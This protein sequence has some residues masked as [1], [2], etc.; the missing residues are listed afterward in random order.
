[1]V[2]HDLLGR[3]RRRLVE[4]QRIF[5]DAAFVWD[6]T[7]DEGAPVPA[8]IYVVR[9]ETLAEGGAPATSGSLALT[10]VDRW[11]R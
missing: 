4:G 8:G 2:V 9:G 6:G 7:D 10:V 1:M 11:S 5:S 3:V